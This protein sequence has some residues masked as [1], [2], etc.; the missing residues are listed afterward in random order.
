MDSIVTEPNSWLGVLS[1][2]AL[3]IATYV[4]KKYVIPFLQVGKREKY[5]RFI[6]TI[7]DE[8]TDDLRGRYPNEEWVKHLDE[9][10]DRLIEIC[11]VSQEIA[12]RSVGAAAARK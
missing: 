2:V 10:I 9:G 5:A 12:R 4:V 6:A 8:V 1:S 11:G 7:A 3:L